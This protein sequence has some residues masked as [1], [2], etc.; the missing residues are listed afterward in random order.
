MY[1]I[2]C[3]LEWNSQFKYDWKR[4]KLKALAD[5]EKSALRN[6]IIQIGAVKCDEFANIVD[7]FKITI[8]PRCHTKIHP[9]VSRKTKITN[10]DLQCG[11][12]FEVAIRHFKNWCGSDYRFVTWGKDDCHE[13][14]KN[15]EHYGI[16]FEEFD[17]YIN[18]QKMFDDYSNNTNS[19]SLKNALTKL[20]ICQDL[21]LHDALNDAL[22]LSYVFFKIIKP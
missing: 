12:D 18:A 20:N 15:C 8:R 11:F 2:F 4:N 14:K 9:V 21:Q 17:E 6:E 1:Y 13:M 10:A 3:D 16:N 19:T 7:T 22:L 5:D